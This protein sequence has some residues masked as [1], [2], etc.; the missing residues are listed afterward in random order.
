MPYVAIENNATITTVERSIVQNTTSGVPTS[1][2]TEA[3]IEVFLDLN[4]L[5]AGDIFLLQYYEKV[6]NG[7]T[8]RLLGQ[9][10][11]TGV[12]GQPNVVLPPIHLKNGY[13]ITL[14]KIAGTDRAIVWSIRE[15]T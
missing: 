7:G 12:Q 5:Q 11:F 15:V 10:H 3:Y 4:T 9:N 6:Q 13:D 1:N 8:Q 14:K 2:T